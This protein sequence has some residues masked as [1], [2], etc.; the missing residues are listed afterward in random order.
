MAI[1]MMGMM[2]MCQ[3]MLIS[4]GTLLRMNI[5]LQR[6]RSTSTPDLRFSLR[7][8]MFQGFSRT[9]AGSLPKTCCIKGSMVITR[10]TSPLESLIG[11]PFASKDSS[12]QMNWTAMDS[13]FLDFIC[14]R[15]VKPGCWTF[16]SATPQVADEPLPR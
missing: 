12:V 14:L 1:K 5:H 11:S 16:N 9:S 10:I 6:S 7:F 15:H 8:K 13:T 3:F 2:G 4:M